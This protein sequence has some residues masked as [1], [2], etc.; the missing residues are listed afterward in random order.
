VTAGPGGTGTTDVT[1]VVSAA[2][3]RS[4]LA[5]WTPR[6]MAAAMAASRA[7]PGMARPDATDATAPPGTPTATEFAGS[8]TVGALFYTT[9]AQEHFC[10]ASV[11]DSTPGD[12]ALT[13]AH[14]VYSSAGY[15]GNI[16][17]V[18]KYHAPWRPR[19]T[20]AVRAIS[21]A[22]GWQAAHD[23]NL[24][25]AFLTMAPLGGKQIQAVTGGLTLAINASY[26]Q[27]IEVIGYNDAIGQ[28]VR[29]ATRS[30][31]FEPG[32]QEFYCHGFRDG[33]SGGPWITGY[34]SQTGTGVVRGVIGGYEDGG[35]YEWA[36]YS[37][38]FGTAIQAL[39][40]HVV[41]GA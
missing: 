4:A 3:Q 5:F 7:T 27:A 10:T 30:F 37:P 26:A 40:D 32:Q 13:A 11:V 38:H 33:T 9:G 29:C 1:Y 31:E 35:V 34:N 2:A 14:C 36:S 25:F 8:P 21:V 16:V 17:Y 28:P 12:I 19:G 41:A 39:Y 24:D 15:A 23:P 22:S 20:W 6:R 18:P